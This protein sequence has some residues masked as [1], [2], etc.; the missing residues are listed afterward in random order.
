MIGSVISVVH[1]RDNFVIVP[2]SLPSLVIKLISPRHSCDN[3][4]IENTVQ[5]FATTTRM[6]LTKKYIVS[7]SQNRKNAEE[8]AELFHEVKEK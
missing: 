1:S 3:L 7:H 8:F 5:Y 2:H 4:Y 6:F